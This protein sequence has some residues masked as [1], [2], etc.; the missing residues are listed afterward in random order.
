MPSMVSRRLLGI[1]TATLTW[2]A[3]VS[4]VFVLATPS[5]GLWLPWATEQDKVKQTLNEIYKALIAD[6]RKMLG[7]Y[8]VGVGTAQFIDY[9]Q[10]LINRMKVK[11]YDCRP[12]SIQIDPGTGSWAFVDLEKIA[13]LENGDTFTQ[14]NMVALKKVAGLWRLLI[15]PRKKDRERK[16]SA[17]SDA[18]AA[19]KEG[20]TTR[21][22][23]REPAGPR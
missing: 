2:L 5:L 8:L 17:Q 20:S 1:P 6:D 10:S 21:E 11:E 4:V 3:A 19:T 9:E 16:S 22:S 23:H 15:E 12:R 14:R 13:K 18:P 7:E